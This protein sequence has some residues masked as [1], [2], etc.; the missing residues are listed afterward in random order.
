MFNFIW[1]STLFSVRRLIFCLVIT[2]FVVATDV[3]FIHLKDIQ[4]AADFATEVVIY[5]L[6]F[7]GGFTIMALFN[8][9]SDN[10]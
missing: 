1:Q 8:Q 7:Y 2:V 3:L 6:G 10:Q 5:T 9:P 4:T